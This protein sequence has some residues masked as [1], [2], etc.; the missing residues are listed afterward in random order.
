MSIK[1]TNT[2]LVWAILGVLITII[3][4][5][6]T[7]KP[8]KHIHSSSLNPN[9][10]IPGNVESIGALEIIL[11][12]ETHRFERT[13][14]DEWIYHND[15]QGHHNTHHHKKTENS[16]KIAYALTG[17]GRIRKER[18]FDFS[19]SDEYGVINPNIYL[20]IYAKPSDSEPSMRISV[21]DLA[22]DTVSRY[23]SVNSRIFTIA[24]FH[25]ENITNL[26]KDT[27]I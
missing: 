22:P 27:K 25:I 3:I 7:G 9:F 2:I 13:N 19:F 15:H 11:S 17:F 24:D 26:I 18:N 23:I 16:E 21:G 1:V 4:A 10:L 14:T 12:G 8:K 20:I 6:P 5:L